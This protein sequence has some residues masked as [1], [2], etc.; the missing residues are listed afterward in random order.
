MFLEKG[1]IKREEEFE[2]YINAFYKHKYSSD[3]AKEMN[4]SASRYLEHFGG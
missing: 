3:F 4:R 1:A 2:E